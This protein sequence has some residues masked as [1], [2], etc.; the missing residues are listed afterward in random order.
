MHTINS[1]QI[2]QK[3]R[4]ISAGNDDE[5]TERKADTLLYTA[6]RLFVYALSPSVPLR[7]RAYFYALMSRRQAAIYANRKG[8]REQERLSKRSHRTKRHYDTYNE[9]EKD[10]RLLAR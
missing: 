3:R 6:R 7:F 8:Y 2:M 4:L 1:A 5:T 10:N 9:Q